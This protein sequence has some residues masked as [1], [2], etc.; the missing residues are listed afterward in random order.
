MLPLK[1]LLPVGQDH[2]LYIPSLGAS[3]TTLLAAFLDLYTSSQELKQHV[4]L[5]TPEGHKINFHC[6]VNPYFTLN[7][8]ARYERL[9]K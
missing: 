3:I 6:H 9:S 8:P 2:A 5:N 7:L 1:A 4:L